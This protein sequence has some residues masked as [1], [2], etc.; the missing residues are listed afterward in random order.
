[1]KH[2]AGLQPLLSVL[3]LLFFFFLIMFCNTC[4]APYSSNTKQPQFGAQLVCVCM[5][6]TLN[7]DCFVSHFVYFPNRMIAWWGARVTCNAGLKS[8]LSADAS[9]NPLHSC[10]VQIAIFFSTDVTHCTLAVKMLSSHHV[11]LVH[12]FRAAFL[13]LKGATLVNLGFI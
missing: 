8:S 2:H 13:S 7:L 10:R 9:S 6:K 12:F 5:C 3:C 4:L 11:T 1:M